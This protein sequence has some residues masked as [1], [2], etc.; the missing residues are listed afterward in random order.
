MM[1][2]VRVTM[3]LVEKA[4]AVNSLKNGAIMSKISGIRTSQVHLGILFE[5][6]SLTVYLLSPRFEYPA[7]ST[8]A[9]VP[10]MI[11]RRMSAQRSIL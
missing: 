10:A 8:N 7:R 4:Y 5:N 1:T 2:M 9:A 11:L 3:T 6:S